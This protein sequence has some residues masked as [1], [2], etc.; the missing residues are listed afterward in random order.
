[1]DEFFSELAVFGKEFRIAKHGT[2]YR[3][4]ALSA[5]Y[6]L[7]PA[8]KLVYTA[9]LWGKYAPHRVQDAFQAVVAPVPFR[10]P[11][12]DG[13]RNAAIDSSFH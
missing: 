10:H 4:N 11:F 3:K 13:P 9:S 5:L 6:A 2:K 7:L 1:M 12:Q 8:L